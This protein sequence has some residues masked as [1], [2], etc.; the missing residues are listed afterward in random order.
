MKKTV[1][2]F[3]VVF[4]LTGFSEILK[5]QGQYLCNF[6]CGTNY[7]L[8]SPAT[9]SLNTNFEGFIKPNRTDT[10]NGIFTGNDSYFPVLVVFVQFKDDPSTDVWPNVS[11]TSGPIYKDSMIATLKN[12]NTNW[13]EAYN[14]NSE[15]LSDYYLQSSRGKM[16]VIGNSYSIVLDSNASYY[17]GLG[18][19]GESVM[20]AEIWRK[21]NQFYTIDWPKFDKWGWDNENST[22]KYENDSIVDF[23]YKI[24][25]TNGDGVMPN[26]YG[27]A[28]LGGGADYEVDTVNHIKINHGYSVY[29]SGITAIKNQKKDGV[30]ATVCHEHAHYIYS[31]GH[32]TYGKL[33]YGVGFDLF[34]SPYEMI[35]NRYIFPREASFTQTNTLGDYS[36]RSSGS[37]EVIKVP[38][39]ETEF[40][41][42]ASRR[43]VSHWD[44]VM[45]GDTAFY[46][47]YNNSDYGKG[48]YIYHVFNG[49]Q[50]PNATYSVPQDLESAD[51]YYR[52]DTIGR[53]EVY[54]NCWTS[55]PTWW[56]FKKAEVLYS[57]D[58]STLGT[59]HFKGDQLSL[60]HFLF[61]N[62]DGSPAG[63]TEKFSIGKKA[64]NNCKLGT[65]RIFTNE[66]EYFSNYNHMGTRYEPWNVGYNEVF[67]PYSSPSTARYN[68]DTSGLFIWYKSFDPSTNEA[69]IDVYK[70]GV[71]YTE[72]QILQMTPPSRP[73][74]VRV[75]DYY[76]ENGWCV[77]I[78]KWNHNKEPDMLRRDTT[79]RYR[80]YRATQPDMNSVPVNYVQI[81][82]VYIHRDSTPSYIDSSILRYDC[83]LLDQTPPYGTKYPVRYE[84][85]AFDTYGDSSVYSDFAS[86]E[87]ISPDGGVEDGGDNIAININLPK[88][89]DLQQNYPNPFNPVTNIKY[90]LPK[91]VFVKIKIYDI[92]GREIKTLVNEFKQAGSYLI[93]FNGSEFASGVY[94]YRIEAGSFIQVKRMVLVK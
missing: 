88:K 61:W 92:L 4:F 81:A 34:N 40:F 94:F 49:V 82:E 73:M 58:P 41:L 39:S 76:P 6:N 50:P 8:N 83:A 2:L 55:D 26:Y 22:F 1:F 80:V 18:Y 48:L 79:K 44:R 42:L 64:D 38:I 54:M 72:S 17:R 71:N 65:D 12:Y 20:T 78:V 13:W 43:K 70:V 86:T 35:Y 28:G 93:S 19:L 29:A 45:L 27:Y 85:K 30:F 87:G 68:D 11:E 52:W 7:L 75:E 25:K 57:N 62:A 16:H 90:N 10:I 66:T 14:P 74:G 15:I 77:P 51:G 21:L 84:I 24:H 47:A 31:W 3:L 32:M 36:S 5:S 9:K 37:G 89:F 69:S 91:D 63:M 53:K 23:I 59:D 46:D 67:S 56:V 60:H 33:M